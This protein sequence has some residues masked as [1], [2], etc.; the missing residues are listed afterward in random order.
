LFSAAAGVAL[1]AAAVLPASAGEPGMVLSDAWVRSVVPSRPAAGYF[2]L[3]NDTG[4]DRKIVSA[5]SPDCGMLMLHLSEHNGSEHM[6][7]VDS[8]DVPAHGSVSFA[9]G[10]YHLMCVKPD[11]QVKPGNSVQMTLTFDDGGVLTADF[12]VRNAKGE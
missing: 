11:E 12:K 2:T 5:S 7:M 10:G 9:P 1:L 3:N 6:A 8:V 4:K